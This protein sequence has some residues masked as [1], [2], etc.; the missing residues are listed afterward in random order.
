MV[1]E[2]SRQELLNSHE[3]FQIHLR[4]QVN[5]G[6]F[7]Q[8]WVDWFLHLTLQFFSHNKTQF[9]NVFILHVMEVQPCFVLTA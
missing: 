8:D 1:I 7:Y 6:S 4:L 9:L 5:N 3:S 2:F